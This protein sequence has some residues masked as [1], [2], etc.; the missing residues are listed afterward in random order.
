MNFSEKERPAE[1]IDGILNKFPINI[2][3]II[4]N[5]TV[6]IGLFG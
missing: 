3:R 6:E 4:E 5:I 2:P 1:K